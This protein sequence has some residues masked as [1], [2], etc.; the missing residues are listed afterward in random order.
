ML[1]ICKLPKTQ[2]FGNSNIFV[3]GGVWAGSDLG[4]NWFCL[5][6]FALEEL[7]NTK[8]YVFAIRGFSG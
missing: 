8:Q 4:L 2:K 7:Y 1:K 3:M 5:V 6:Q